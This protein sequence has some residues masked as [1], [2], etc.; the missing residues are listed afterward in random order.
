MAA[1]RAHSLRIISIQ[2]AAPKALFASRSPRS[3]RAIPY[4]ALMKGPSTAVAIVDA[5]ITTTTKVRNHIESTTLRIADL[6]RPCRRRSR[7]AK[8]SRSCCALKWRWTADGFRG[9]MCGLC[10]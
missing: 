7:E 3:E 2:K 5:V 4:S 1:G 6:A 8:L 10:S 9:G